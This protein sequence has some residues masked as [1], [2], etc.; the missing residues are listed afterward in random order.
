MLIYLCPNVL[1]RKQNRYEKWLNPEYKLHARR[2]TFTIEEFD[3]VILNAR[4]KLEIPVGPA[5]PCV[6]RVRVATAE[7]P[8]Q[9]AAV[10]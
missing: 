6:T 1:K 2:G 9:K 8:T 10:S 3:A 7:T 4:K 5:M